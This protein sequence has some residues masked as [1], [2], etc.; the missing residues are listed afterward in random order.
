MIH[1]GI[2]VTGCI[3][4]ESGLRIL[5][6]KPLADAASIIDSLVNPI[7]DATTG[8]T[9]TSLDEVP[10]FLQVTYSLTHCVSILTDEVRL[11]VEAIHLLLHYLDFWIHV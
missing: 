4:V 5:Q 2:V 8:N 1:L 10:V 9:S 3:V 6:R 7:P 11:V